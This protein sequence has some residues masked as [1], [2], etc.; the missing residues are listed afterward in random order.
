MKAVSNINGEI[1][2]FLTEKE[3][4]HF[5]DLDQALIDLDGTPNKSRLGANAILAVSMACVCACAQSE[6]MQLWEFLASQN[7]SNKAPLSSGDA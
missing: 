6:K 3:F 5:S 1:A 4:A 2:E 7:S